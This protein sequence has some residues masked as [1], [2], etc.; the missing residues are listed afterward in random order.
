M[1][2]LGKRGA[3]ALGSEERKRSLHT[4]GEATQ[5]AKPYATAENECQGAWSQVRRLRRPVQVGR[6][7]AA[8]GGVLA[9]L[10]LRAV[11]AN[12]R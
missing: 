6:S 7:L 11:M 8:Q 9:L 3:L 5:T 1:I 12:R 4:R 2:A 10:L